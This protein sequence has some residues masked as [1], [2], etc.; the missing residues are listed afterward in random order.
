MNPPAV[1]TI[2]VNWNTREVLRDCL[3]TVH[4]Q[5]KNIPFEAIVV[6]NASEDG[7]VDMVK[8][9][10]PQAVLPANATNHGGRLSGFERRP[11]VAAHVLHVPIRIEHPDRSVV[12]EQTVPAQAI[13]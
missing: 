6:D 1:S 10:F 4:E 5:T 13:Q 12:A 2:I 8:T 11:N 3:R 9:V 7:S